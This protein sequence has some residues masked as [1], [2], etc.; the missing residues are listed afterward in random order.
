MLNVVTA[1]QMFFFVVQAD[2][3][4]VCADSNTAGCASIICNGNAISNVKCNT[5]DF[6]YNMNSAIHLTPVCAVYNVCK[7]AM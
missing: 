4:G 1:G 6:V 7:Y 3:P 2:C 5:H